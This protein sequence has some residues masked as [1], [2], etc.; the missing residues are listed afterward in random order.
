MVPYYFLLLL[1]AN[2]SNNATTTL[3]RQ[4]KLTEFEYVYAGI[5]DWICLVVLTACVLVI[6]SKIGCFNS[7]TEA[8][9]SNDSV[10]LV[11]EEV[12]VNVGKKWVGVL[13]A[14]DTSR[15]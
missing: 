9:G 13:D 6:A 15:T 7:A 11:L 10:V 14:L 12:S 4:L 8:I 5:T 3:H 1:P 2:A